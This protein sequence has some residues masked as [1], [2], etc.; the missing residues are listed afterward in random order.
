MQGEEAIDVTAGRV[1]AI[2]RAVAILRCFNGHNADLGISDIARRTGLS[3]STTQRLLVAMGAN[4][5]VRPVERGRFRLGPFLST[6]AASGALDGELR[7]V[8]L[9]VMRRVRDDV[10]ETVA[11]HGYMAPD[12]RVVIDQVESRQDLRRTYTDIGIPAAVVH[13]APGK[14]IVFAL[15]QDVRDGILATPIEAVTPHTVTDPEVLRREM[16]IAFARGYSESEQERTIGIRTVGAAV[17]DSA[18]A[19]VGA[20]G[21]SVPVVRMDDERAAELGATVRDAA[22]EISTALG[23]SADDVQARLP[24]LKIG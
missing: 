15:P 18:A 23:A 6:L 14:A 7:S 13:G 8:A 17:F 2:D 20:L 19:V 3:T 9:P 1:R 5:L 12:R 22:W 21:I 4:G 16:E 24:G 11:I 10:D